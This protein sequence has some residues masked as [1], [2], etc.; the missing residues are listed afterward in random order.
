M[1]TALRKMKKG[2]GKYETFI[3]RRRAAKEAAGAAVGAA[4]ISG[5]GGYA[6][7]KKKGQEKKAGIPAAILGA[8]TGSIPPVGA[9]YGAMLGYRR[10]E[11]KKML[12]KLTEVES[13]KKDEKKA[14]IEKK[15]NI[16][17]EKIAS[18]IKESGI[19]DM[20]KHLIRSKLAPAK[21]SLARNIQGKKTAPKGFSHVTKT[22]KPE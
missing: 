16:Y 22:T 10:G 4:A 2:F 12:N 3:S 1:G 14:V 19:G 21:L 20:G 8:L 17:L 7:G 9:A 13:K 6:L 18:L 15:G 11:H 5:A